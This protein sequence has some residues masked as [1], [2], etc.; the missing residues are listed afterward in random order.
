MYTGEYPGDTATP[1]KLSGLYKISKP[2]GKRCLM[3]AGGDLA[4]MTEDGIVPMSKVTSL[5][6][7]ALQ[8]AAVTAPI[9]PAW[10]DAVLGPSGAIR[11][12]DHHLAS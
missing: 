1:W 10:R 7:V 11:L 3:K 6:Q 5:D 9:A 2:L 4:I 12:A 8:N